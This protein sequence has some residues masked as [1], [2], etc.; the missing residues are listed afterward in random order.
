MFQPQERSLLLIVMSAVPAVVLLIACANVATL[1]LA[2]AAARQREVAIRLSVGSDR[3][4]LIRQLLTES[5][6]MAVAGR[7][8]D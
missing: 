5:L 4:R 8:A 2:R 6:V 7:T 1:L 3:M